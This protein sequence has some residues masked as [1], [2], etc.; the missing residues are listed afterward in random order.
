MK[1]RALTNVL[2]LCLALAL[3]ACATRPVSN[4]EAAKIPQSRILSARYLSPVPNSGTV[5]VKRDSGIGGSAC[6]VRLFV[7]G[8]PTADVRSAEKIVLYLPENEYVL[9]AWPNGICGGGMS[10][11]TAQVKAGEKTNFRIGYGSNGDFF[12][13]RTAF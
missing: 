5:T 2:A 8:Q 7:N 13:N 12:I 11:T 6:S 1:L 10:E 4:F 9:S 3:S